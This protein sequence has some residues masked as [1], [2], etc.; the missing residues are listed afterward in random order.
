MAMVGY[1]MVAVWYE[2]P[3]GMSG[4]GETLWMGMR[5]RVV[6]VFFSGCFPAIVAA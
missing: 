3:L 2:Q 5:M 4:M 6:V 1:A